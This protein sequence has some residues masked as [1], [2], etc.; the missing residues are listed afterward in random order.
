[1]LLV[2]LLL[3]LMPHNYPFLI[4]LFFYFSIEHRSQ[5]GLYPSQVALV[6]L[7]ANQL[8]YSAVKE[9]Q[10]GRLSETILNDIVQEVEK[11]ES[12]VSA[13]PLF[14][15]PQEYQNG[16]MNDTMKQLLQEETKTTEEK[17]GNFINP[18]IFKAS[19]DADL[20]EFYGDMI[21]IEKILPLDFSLLPKTKS[22]A[23]IV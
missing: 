21:K 12:L 19:I 20:S 6:R 15:G 13:L 16:W 5:R 1:M 17:P 2:M 10:Q 9:S 14:G 18:T 3:M 8:G 11:I 23:I 4:V 7:S 22:S